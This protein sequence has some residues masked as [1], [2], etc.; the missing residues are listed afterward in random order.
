MVWITKPDYKPTGKYAFGLL[1]TSVAPV[2]LY[3]DT[4]KASGALLASVLGP[5]I[6]HPPSGIPPEDQICASA[7]SSLGQFSGALGQIR[8]T[9]QLQ[10]GVTP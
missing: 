1:Q 8:N 4:L 2:A 5:S 6:Q 3:N 10:G 9:F 7:L